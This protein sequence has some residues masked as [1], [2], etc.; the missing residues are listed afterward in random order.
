MI[1]KKKNYR[2]DIPVP[3]NLIFHFENRPKVI[4]SMKFMRLGAVGE[5]LVLNLSNK[6][7]ASTQGSL[8]QWSN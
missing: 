1:N 7:V 2:K 3:D 8:F 5:C 4:K 6:L